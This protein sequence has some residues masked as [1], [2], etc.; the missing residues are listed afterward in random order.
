[1]LV[2]LLV[3]GSNLS[4]IA[5]VVVSAGSV[6]AQQCTSHALVEA[7]AVYRTHRTVLLAQVFASGSQRLTQSRMRSGDSSMDQ[8]HSEL[9]DWISWATAT[10]T[11]DF[12]LVL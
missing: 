5:I 1:M 6:A 4:N 10:Q 11:G 3:G 9:Q 2:S 8:Q 7:N 12:T